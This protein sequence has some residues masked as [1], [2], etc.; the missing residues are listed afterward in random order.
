MSETGAIVIL[1][2]VDENLGF[3]FQPTKSAAMNDSVS[4]SLEAGSHYV[5]MLIASSPLR[6]GR[7]RSPW[8]E[9]LLLS[10]L[11]LLSVV[12]K[13]SLEMKTVYDAS[14]I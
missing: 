7:M 6:G 4:V 11:L 12:H 14:L 5:R 13:F 8:S 9:E 1:F 10:L 3:M 2:R